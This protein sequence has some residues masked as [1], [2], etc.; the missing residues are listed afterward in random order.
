MW[1]CHKLGSSMTAREQTTWH[2][3]HDLHFSNSLQNKDVDAAPLSPTSL[4]NLMGRGRAVPFFGTLILP[5]PVR[6][7]CCWSGHQSWWWGDATWWQ[8]IYLILSW[9][10]T[11]AWLISGFYKR[12]DKLASCIHSR[13]HT[14]IHTCVSVHMYTYACNACAPESMLSASQ[15]YSCLFASWIWVETLSGILD[16]PL[17]FVSLTIIQ[18]SINFLFIAMATLTGKFLGTIAP[19]ECMA[20][21][22]SVLCNEIPFKGGGWLLCTNIKPGDSKV[23]T[24]CWRAP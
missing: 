6:C 1:R 10:T 15:Y 11:V 16:L 21:T 19:Q 13:I 14:R 22:R 12:I 24:M 4:C 5:W 8:Q 23:V 3:F 17:D 9:M 7:A 20:G 18:L 2:S